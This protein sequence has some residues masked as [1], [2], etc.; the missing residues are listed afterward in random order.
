MKE[1][2][3]SYLR[4]PGFATWGLWGM[5]GPWWE[6]ARGP[7]LVRLAVGDGVDGRDVIRTNKMI[8]EIDIPTVIVP[9]EK[10]K[11]A[12][13]GRAGLSVSH[14]R[15][16]GFATWVPWDMPGPRAVEDAGHSK[17]GWPRGRTYMSPGSNS[18]NIASSCSK[19]SSAV[20]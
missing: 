10:A 13:I 16:P 8:L 2:V 11:V 18:L 4:G 7:R 12:V 9:P 17:Y 15:G 6:K 1:E 19:R 5:P 20:I 14:L 3:G